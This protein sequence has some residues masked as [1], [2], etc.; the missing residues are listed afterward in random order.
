[1]H[2]VNECVH[3]ACMVHVTTS[4]AP[5]VGVCHVCKM[6]ARTNRK[7]LVGACALH[8]R[9]AC[10]LDNHVHCY[11]ECVA[12]D[13][14]TFELSLAQ[15]LASFATNNIF[16]KFLSATNNI[17]CKLLLATKNIFHTVV[18]TIVDTLCIP[19]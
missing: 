12:G 8:V 19:Y 2:R 17:F 3:D 14:L 6:H 16:C 15:M 18:N 13:S 1:M 9:Q 4:C 5:P 10:A 7:T 11:R